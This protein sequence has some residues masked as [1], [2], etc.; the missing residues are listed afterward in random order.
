M[1]ARLRRVFRAALNNFGR[2]GR[3]AMRVWVIGQRCEAV[4]GGGLV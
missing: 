4:A 3:A 1:Y 2:E